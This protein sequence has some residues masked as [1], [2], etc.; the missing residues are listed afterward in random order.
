MNTSTTSDGTISS[1]KSTGYD[2]EDGIDFFKELQNILKPS[3]VCSNKVNEI[4][5]H[6]HPVVIHEDDLCMLSKEPLDN[7]QI[8]LDC[9]HRFN[10]VPLYKDVCHQKSSSSQMYDITT[11]GAG[12]IKCPYCRAK[13]SRLLP[14]IVCNGVKR[15]YGVNSPEYY[16]MPIFRCCYKMSNVPEKDISSSEQSNSP[17]LCGK[18]NTLNTK[19]G[20]LCKLHFRLMKL[21]EE[22]AAKAAAKQQAKIAKSQVIST[23]ETTCSAVYVSGKNKGSKC[24]SKVSGADSHYCKRHSKMNIPVI[25]Q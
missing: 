6:V 20:F 16:C 14:F 23:N 10:Y 18:G 17:K 22:R 13:T 3:E 2:V 25:N 11:L 15:T 1:N 8:K 4:V 7:T 24:S 9:G 5:S 19:Y 21:Q 12:Q